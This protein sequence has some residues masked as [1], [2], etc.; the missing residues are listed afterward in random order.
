VELIFWRVARGKGNPIAFAIYAICIWRVFFFLFVISSSRKGI[1]WVR[2]P[3]EI[4]ARPNDTPEAAD[5]RISCDSEARNWFPCHSE[6]ESP[7]GDVL[8]RCA[9]FRVK[10]SFCRKHHANARAKPKEAHKVVR[11]SNYIR[12]LP[13]KLLHYIYLV[14]WR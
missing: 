5:V 1:S 13:I 4:S 8:L 9:Y 2:N 6:A 12:L 10:V 7:D 3:F 11:V 14:F